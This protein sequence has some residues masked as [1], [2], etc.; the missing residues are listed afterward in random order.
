MGE[1]YFSDVE[2]FTDC[3]I[4]VS[5]N[6]TVK[7]MK[8]LSESEEDGYFSLFNRKVDTMFLRDIENKEFTNPREFTSED[9][10]NFDVVMAG[11]V[12]SILPIHVRRRRN[13]GGLGV[14]PSST[15]SD[16][17]GSPKNSKKS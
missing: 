17:I 16:L 2:G 4:E 11:F 1:K 12:G 6:W 10:E 9:L 8:E 7:E 5:D 3:F 14:R 15:G 13:L